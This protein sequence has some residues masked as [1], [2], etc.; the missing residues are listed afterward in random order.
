MAANGEMLSAESC[1]S[2]SR[3]RV[4][5]SAAAGF[6]AV[7]L[8]QITLLFV[9]DPAL[10]LTDHRVGPRYLS[11]VSP[12]GTFLLPVALA[13]AVVALSKRFLRQE[14]VDFSQGMPKVE[15]VV[16]IGLAFVVLA[17]NLTLA[18]F[19]MLGVVWASA[20]MGS[21][22][23]DLQ[24]TTSTGM[25]IRLYTVLGLF[26]SVGLALRFANLAALGP[27]VDANLHLLK[28]IAPTFGVDFEY[29][30][31]DVVTSVVASS[32]SLLTPETFNQHLVAARLPGVVLGAATAIPIFIIGKRINVR[33]GMIAAAVW[34]LHPF[35]IAMSRY[36]REYAYFAF[37]S[38]VLLAVGLTL[39]LR[40]RGSFGRQA[41]VVGAVGIAMFRYASWDSA[42]TFRANT[43]LTVGTLSLA[44]L[45]LTYIDSDFRFRST[46]V[47]Q[48][49][50]ALGVFG[51]IVLRYDGRDGSLSFAI[52]RPGIRMWEYYAGGMSIIQARP[53]FVVLVVGLVV[54]GFAAADTR[55]KAVIFGLAAASFGMFLAIVNLWDRWD[56]PYYTHFLLPIMVLLVGV[57]FDAALKVLRGVFEPLR[58][59]S[60]RSAAVEIAA[61][62][63]L[64]PF[65]F[66]AL[67]T[68]EILR[69]LREPAPRF[70]SHMDS[71]ILI[72]QV[73]S[74]PAAPQATISTTSYQ[75]TA[76][77]SGL[78]PNPYLQYRYNDVERHA[79]VTEAFGEFATGVLALDR[80]RASWS[81]SV[82]M[83]NF[84]TI[85]AGVADV[86]VR[87]DGQYGD[88]HLWTWGYGSERDCDGA[89]RL[90]DWLATS[91]RSGLLFA[92]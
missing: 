84:L 22:S 47:A 55:G 83:D 8:T 27:G 9:L 59:D 1:D 89:V 24:E 28:A 21:W 53:A 66:G 68:S 90:E 6:V 3:T 17:P 76:L 36:V 54:L 26:V 91:D 10:Q 39:V 69:T 35:S 41:A 75:V 78:D 32:F 64:F 7:V 88:F 51:V 60:T 92:G 12:F 80:Q 73:Q 86:C 11:S 63:V 57:A 44:V 14:K 45:L 58:I 67:N 46:H 71:R 13:V 37:A 33:V 65:A 61:A 4:A 82:P 56:G 38:S 74:L 79:R 40:Y 5:L 43:I 20:T 48:G 70:V 23:V 87:Y 72:S 25:R 30:R 19:V 50:V 85:R 18:W 29:S 49:V 52:D 62:V 34:S 77:L 15:H 42:S 81:L 2:Q 16:L 31:A